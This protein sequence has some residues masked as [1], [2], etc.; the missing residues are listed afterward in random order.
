MNVNL[1]RSRSGITLT[2]I[3]ISILIM[4]IGLMSLASLFPVGLERIRRGQQAQRSATF[5]NS[6]SADIGAKNL[7]SQ[8]SFLAM[9]WYGVLVPWPSGTGFGYDP[10][11]QD[12]PLPSAVNA[13]GLTNGGVYRGYGMLGKFTAQ[14][15]PL[16]PGVGLTVAYDPLWWAAMF[17][18]TSGAINPATSAAPSR[19][20]R[21]VSTINPSTG[22]SASGVQASSYGLPRLTNANPLN[23]AVVTSTFFSPD[24]P[25]L[26]QEGEIDPTNPASGK[27]SPILPLLDLSGT[28][29][30]NPTYGQ[31]SFDWTVSWFFTGRRADV[32]S[33]AVYEGDVVVCYNRPFGLENNANGS[34]TVAGERV[35]QAVF[36]YGGIPQVR[37]ASGAAMTTLAGARSGFSPASRTV[38]LR[39]P[40]TG[41]KA[42]PD[43]EVKLGSWIADVTYE[44][45]DAAEPR[46]RANVDATVDAF[47]GLGVNVPFAAESYPAQRCNW[48][49]VARRT[50]PQDEVAGSPLPS[51]TTGYRYMVLT[52]E[53]P[54]QAKTLLKPNGDPVFTNVALVM[55]SVINVFPRVFYVR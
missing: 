42:E 41:A 5:V 33:T 26:Q 36:G 38:L 20:G 47:Y 53:S 49:R 55:P 24:D 48:Y 13:N 17:Y 2:E 10:W 11:I 39:W 51:S 34:T 30:T 46:F 52:V 45:L 19:L 29:A 37:L 23:S 28:A 54:L 18:Q 7:L 35:V 14:T 12:L 27:G 4:G 43:P 22:D 31:M 32:A 8:D 40:S 3:L 44:Q 9:P 15:F 6:A 1:P 25:V 21:N 50:D 16:R